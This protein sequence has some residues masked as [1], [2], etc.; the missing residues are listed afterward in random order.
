MSS[1]PDLNKQAQEVIILQVM[2]KSFHSHISFNI[3]L[4]IY[5]NDKMNFHYHVLV[6]NLQINARNR[7]H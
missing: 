5:L 6:R 4:G 2:I 3:I 1:N 7:C